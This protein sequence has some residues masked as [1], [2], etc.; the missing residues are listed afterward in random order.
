MKGSEL[1]ATEQMRLLQKQLCPNA[2]H[3]GGSSISSGSGGTDCRR[4]IAI[5]LQKCNQL[6]IAICIRSLC[7]SQYHFGPHG[8]VSAQELKRI[9]NATQHTSLPT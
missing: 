2:E 1:K 5:L 9:I 7:I 8:L 6:C 3:L 4:R